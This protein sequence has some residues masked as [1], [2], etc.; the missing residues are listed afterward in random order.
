MSL[1][2]TGVSCVVVTPFCQGLVVLST[3]VS[4]SSSSCSEDGQQAVYYVGTLRVCTQ[5]PACMSCFLQRQTQVLNNGRD[6]PTEKPSTRTAVA[7]KADS[8]VAIGLPAGHMF[9]IT[10]DHRPMSRHSPESLAFPL[11]SPY[12]LRHAMKRR[13]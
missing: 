5:R 9:Y 4:S 6:G 7:H 2:V 11:L 1:A 13:S 12:E 8:Y 3:F 10:S